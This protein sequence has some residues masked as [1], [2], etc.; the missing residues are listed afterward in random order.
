MSSKTISK[1]L[2]HLYI[3]LSVKLQMFALSTKRKKSLINENSYGPKI[4]H[5][6]KNL[7]LH[8]VFDLIGTLVKGLILIY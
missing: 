4:D 2:L 5:Y 3:M 1:S 6:T 8:A 7:L